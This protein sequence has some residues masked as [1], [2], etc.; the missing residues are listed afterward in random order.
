MTEEQRGE[1]KDNPFRKQSN[2]ASPANQ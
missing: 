1:V 2:L